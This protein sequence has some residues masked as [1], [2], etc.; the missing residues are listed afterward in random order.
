VTS[1]GAGRADELRAALVARLVQRG[2]LAEGSWSHI[3]Q[4]VPR[5]VFVPA[6]FVPT[7]D[8][9]VF[10]AVRQGDPGWLDA[11]YTNAS[12]VTQLD[13]TLD[14]CSVDGPVRGVPTSSSSA[15]GL[16]ATVLE[17]AD[18]RPG[19]RILEIG[20]G[21]GYNAAVLCE[22]VGAAN[23]TTIDIDPAITEQA[24]ARL[25]SLGY[26]PTVTL[27]DGDLGLPA[28]APYDRI[29]ATCSVHDI[30]AAWLAQCSPGA[31]IV[32]NLW[33]DLESFAL[34]RLTVNGDR[35][36]TGHLLPASGAYMPTRSYHQI[37][38]LDLWQHNAKGHTGHTRPTAVRGDILDDTDFA[39]YAA[40]QLDG[41]STL[42]VLA[43]T[44]APTERWLLDRPG[45]WACWRD[46]PTNPT[47]EQAGDR[48]L[49][50]ELEAAHAT[51]TQLGRPHKAQL[52]VTV[53]PDGGTTISGP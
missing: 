46:H 19:H 48:H 2:D 42:H 29:I 25:A 4:R 36:G 32:A 15:P 52:A 17:A 28:H 8:G 14:P 6:F 11:V 26:H 50:D 35:T 13:S 40:F 7:D 1:A 21:T 3:F 39:T 31:V 23:V 51:W 53:T 45:S 9:A 16:M 27:A 37:D 41:V 10:R 44:G 33:R 30:P 47:V 49:W 43:E 20:A 12:L 5:H 18:I 38:P 24:E 34:A 22:R